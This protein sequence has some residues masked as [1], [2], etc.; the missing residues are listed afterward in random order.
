[1]N[2]EG[3]VIRPPSEAHS[4]ILQ[5]TV[6][7]FHNLCSFCRAYK[8]KK[9]RIKSR[10]EILA[11]LEFAGQYCRQQ[12]T[13]FLADGDTL[14]IPYARLV[15]ILKDIRYHLPSV[16]RISSYASCGSI[17]AK[18]IERLVEL[19]KLGLSRLYMGLESGDDQVLEEIKK[20]SD[21]KEMI[22]AGRMV[23]QAGIFLSVTCLLGI[24]GQDKSSQHARATARVL[25]QMRP[26]QIAVLTLMLTG[27]TELAKKAGAGLFIMPPQ[28]QLLEEL[29]TMVAGLVDIRA[30]FQA[31]HA[32]NYLA[33]DGRLP[34]DRQHFLN[35]LDLAIKGRIPLK[36]EILR[37]L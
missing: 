25:C 27:N 19:K 12:K 9:F 3:T 10:E 21:S 23:R 29:R 35:L 11:D 5:V 32:S 17:L 6:G 13:V 18:N 8:D 20:G 4:I 37:A 7:C 28:Q 31:N 2:Y 33:L 15:Q 34:R 30:Q 16:R 26:S 14:T 36:E 22:E 24:A 1:M